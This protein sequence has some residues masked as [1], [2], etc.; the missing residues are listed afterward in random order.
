[1]TKADEYAREC[2]RYG[3]LDNPDSPDYD[4]RPDTENALCGRLDWLWRTMTNDERQEA[5]R[6]LVE[7]DT[8]D[9]LAAVA[10]GKIVCPS[11]DGSGW[12][13]VV[14]DGHGYAG[15]ACRCKGGLCWN[16]KPN[17]A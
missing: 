13:A 6:Q 3:N 16:Y 15:G 12:V 14:R 1:M 10:A 4:P 17:A 5:G 9:T 7:M 2:H 8:R 11:C